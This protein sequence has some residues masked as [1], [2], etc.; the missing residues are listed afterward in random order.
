[1]T[2]FPQKK[3]YRQRAHANPFSDHQ[4]DYPLNPDSIDWAVHYPN[5]EESKRVVE[6]ADVGCGYGGLLV[7]L[8]PLFPDKLMLGM[9]IRNK[10]CDFVRDRIVALRENSNADPHTSAGGDGAVTTT[11]TTTTKTSS[12]ASPVA[13]GY[14]NI[15]VVRTNAMKFLPNFFKRGQ[16]SKM[17][18]LFPDPHFKKKKHKA[19][20]INTSFLADYAYFLQE[21]GLLYLATDVHDL[22][23]WMVKHCEAHPLFSR[24]AEEDLQ[25]DPVISHILN[26]TEEGIKVAR[27]QGSKWYAV[28]KRVLDPVER[29]SISSSM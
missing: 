12:V 26:S 21:G 8:S 14:Q 3:Y 19:R 15:S 17:F 24:V 10:V 18:F 6:F 29:S 28:Y 11:T 2:T 5:I 16:L 22:Y 1:M 7:S 9:E 13:N 27:N 4:L 23:E 25:G 20:I